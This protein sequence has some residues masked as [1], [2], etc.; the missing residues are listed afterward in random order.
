L[1]ADPVRHGVSH[2]Q[3]GVSSKIPGQNGRSNAGP[4]SNT[5]IVHGVNNTTGIAVS[6]AYKL[7]D[8]HWSR[9]AHVP[10]PI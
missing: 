1:Q 7:N 8:Q 6:E 4:I 3:I 10:G 9:H 5:S 2:T